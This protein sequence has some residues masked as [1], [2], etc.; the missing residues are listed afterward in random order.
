MA[1]PTKGPLSTC[2]VHILRMLLKDTTRWH[3]LSC[4]KTFL[5]LWFLLVMGLLTP[6]HYQIPILTLYYRCAKQT[7]D[8]LSSHRVQGL[9]K[10]SMSLALG[11]KAKTVGVWASCLSRNKG[12]EHEER[13]NTAQ[14]EGSRQSD[15]Q[16][17][18]VRMVVKQY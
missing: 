15:N 6:W 10:T 13:D 1:L 5:K 17:E 9:F 12:P 11:A 7:Q 4:L 2:T 18:T 14:K 8:T 16:G 3:K